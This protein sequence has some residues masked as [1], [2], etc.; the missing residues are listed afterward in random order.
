M[1]VNFGGPQAGKIGANDR[2][3]DSPKRHPRSPNHE[4]RR[5]PVRVAREERGKRSRKLNTSIRASALELAEKEVLQGERG[6]S[7]A[8]RKNEFLNY[9]NNLVF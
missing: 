7:R 9:I 6:A 3:P 4:E 5:P 2:R 1:L 8:N